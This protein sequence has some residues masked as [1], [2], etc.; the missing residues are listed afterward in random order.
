[1]VTGRPPFTGDNPVAIA[2]QHV[3]E[4]P[5]PLS[6]RQPRRPPR[7]SRPS[8]SRPWPRTPTTAT[9]TA[10]DLRA[11]LLRFREGKAVAAE[12]TA[13]GRRRR[14]RRH[15]G[16]DAAWRSTVEGGTQVLSA[17][18]G[19][20][21]HGTGRRARTGTYIGLLV[22]LLAVARPA[23]V[24][25]RPAAR[26]LRRPGRGHRPRRHRQDRGRGGE[27]PRGRGVQGRGPRA[28][29]RHRR[30]RARCSPR[31]RP[32]TSRPRRA[33]R[34]R[35]GQQRPAL[36]HGAVGDRQDRRGGE[37]GTGRPGVPGDPK[38][39]PVF[40]PT[41]PIGPGGRPEPRRRQPAAA[42][43]GVVRLT[44]SKGPPADDH[45]RAPRP[46]TTEATTPP[47]QPTFFPPTTP[48]HDGAR[49]RR[50][51]RTRRATP[52]PTGRGDTPGSSPAAAGRPG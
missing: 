52:A 13:I 50:S 4:Q 18:R 49:R 16:D 10:E 48:A 40:D 24:S 27:D 9:R 35:F 5:V 21:H 22:V 3:R 19:V 33:T 12:P 14:R 30:P 26:A 34:S 46:P 38:N 2:Y 36:R 37:Q 25:A 42:D 20:N 11:D 28:A 1:M 43:G 6:E 8:S 41:A 15:R 45:R 47:T 44:T 39:T 7:P 29:Q 17:H 32:P 51:P 23:A 31:T